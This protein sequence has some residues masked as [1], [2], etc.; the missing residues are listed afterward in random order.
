M[1]FKSYIMIYCIAP[2]NIK[3]QELS[4]KLNTLIKKYFPDTNIVLESNT[5]YWKDPN[6]NSIIYSIL[7]NHHVKVANVITLFPISWDYSEGY[8][9]NLD[10]Q[11]R[12]NTENAVWSQLCHPEE[13]FLDS[14]VDWAHIYTSET[15]E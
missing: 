13:T 9:Y 7:N 2:N 4:N 1:K 11:Q 15:A 10:I 12:V 8:A 3:V 6:S 5:P 14:K